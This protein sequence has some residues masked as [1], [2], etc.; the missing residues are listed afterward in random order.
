M[1]RTILFRGKRIDNGEW[2]EGDLIHSRTACQMWI[3]TH[4]IECAKHTFIQPVEVIPESVGQY[5]G[6]TDKNGVKV[7]EGD[8]VNFEDADCGF[9]GYHDDVFTNSGTVEYDDGAMMYYFTNRC[10]VDMD[11]LTGADIEVI[12]NIHDNP[13]LLGGDGE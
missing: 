6:L 13:K 8:V 7:F 5:T 10:T 3:N 9:E 1:I 2:V 4:N 12:G 11:D